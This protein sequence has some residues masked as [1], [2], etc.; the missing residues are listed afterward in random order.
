M[1]NGLHG[2]GKSQLVK[3]FADENG[4]DFIDIRLSQIDATDLIGLPDVSGETTK[5]KPPAW[6]PQ[7]PNSK[8]ILFLDELFRGRR[9]VL[10]AVF[11]LVLDRKTASYCL[12]EGWHVVSANNPSTDD[13]DVT[14]VFDAALL[15]RFLHIKLEP[16]KAEWFDYVKKDESVDQMFVEYLQTQEGM[17]EDSTLK[18]ADFKRKPSRR[19][20]HLAG[21]LLKTG[22]PSNLMI[23]AIA[24]L[25][26]IESAIAF[27]AYKKDNETAPFKPEEILTKL[28]DI[29]DK[30]VKYAD[31]EKGRHDVLTVSLDN[32][33][34]AI[35]QKQP[36]VK[37]T[38][39]LVVFL[40]LIPK[41]MSVGFVRTLAVSNIKEVTA[42]CLEVLF[43]HPDIDE[44]LG[45]PAKEKA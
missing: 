5:F 33:R 31:M 45:L 10:Q 42:Y 36:T 4:L 8:G 26:G 24:G 32:L 25:V 12:P 27:D 17:I 40:K 22:L 11:Q 15:D 6:L 23:E 9:D 28:K 34:M 7:D 14:N 44:A 2:I 21:R 39:N 16:T 30:V 41:D 18:A 13:Y 43:K 35:E 19:S 29:K 38:D 20:N 37:Q 3:Q 1:I